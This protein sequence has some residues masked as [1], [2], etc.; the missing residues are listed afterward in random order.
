[1][2]TEL[3]SGPCIAMEVSRKDEGQNVIADFRNL[4]GPRDPVSISLIH[5]FIALLTHLS[6]TFQDIARQIRPGTLRAKYGKTKAQ[7]AVHC[8]DLPEDGVLEVIRVAIIFIY[9]LNNF[10]DLKFFTMYRYCIRNLGFLGRIF[11]Q[12]T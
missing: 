2:V 6:V 1:M 7:N 5:S 10:T 11:L 4:C 3:H 12:D 8:S 9:N